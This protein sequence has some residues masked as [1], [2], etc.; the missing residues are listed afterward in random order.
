M[1]SRYKNLW[2]PDG[3]DELM[4]PTLLKNRLSRS[5]VLIL[6]LLAIGF[7][8]SVG[9]LFIDPTALILSFSLIGLIVGGILFTNV[10]L[11]ITWMFPFTYLIVRDKSVL[12][13]AALSAFSFLV[14]RLRSG[15]ISFIVP[16]PLAIFVLIITGYIGATLA[17]DKGLGNYGL[18]HSLLLMIVIFII[19][20]N[21]D[22]STDQI[23]TFML[24]IC[25][26]TALL[27]WGT[28]VKYLVIGQEREVFGWSTMNRM[29]GFMGLI[30]PYSLLMML[31]SS[32]IKLRIIWL[33]ILLG[34]LSALLVTQTRAIMLSSFL[35]VFYIGIKDRRAWIVMVSLVFVALLVAP[36]LFLS[37][38]SMTVG[39]GEIPDWSSVGR[40]QIWMNSLQFIPQYFWFGMGI[41]SFRVLYEINFP[42]AFIKA[43]HV[44]N[45]YIYWLFSYGIFGMIANMWIM[46]GSL[47]W[48]HRAVIR[49]RYS[50]KWKEESL[51]LTGLNAGIISIMVASMVDTYISVPTIGAL[52]WTILALQLKLSRRMTDEQM[53]DG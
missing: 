21:V 23:K 48:G 52:F 11:F 44:H 38:L 16:Y 53:T 9:V 27:G 41:D 3:S 2:Q 46:F 6:L 10:A 14:H 12:L 49:T 30:I 15:N 39:K 1:I 51:V 34:L 40:L 25:L 22:L 4:Q 36:S 37:R 31:K 29:A 18:I 32:S 26:I 42:N 8:L 17:I 45:N 35:V 47:W 19:Y 20:Y 13:L 28:L 24:L 5:V 50:D 7:S 33:W 43:I